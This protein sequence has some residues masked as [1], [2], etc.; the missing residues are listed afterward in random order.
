HAEGN[1]VAAFAEVTR[2]MSNEAPAWR[3]GLPP[4]MS[5]GGVVRGVWQTGAPVWFP[6]VARQ[7]DFRRGAG[8]AKAGLHR[9]FRFPILAVGQALGVMEFYARDIKAPDEVL[10][11]IVRAIGSQIGQFMQRKEA[12][13]A[14]RVS[15]E[16]YRAQFDESPLPM[17][18]WDD[19]T[20]A[21]L[22]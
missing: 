20:L 4:R 17:W 2:D 14:L 18:V 11:Q 3:G 9:A 8:A 16:R 7:S 19:H 21:I 12:E 22:S 1:E 5:S 15:E 10:L 6:D 13:Q